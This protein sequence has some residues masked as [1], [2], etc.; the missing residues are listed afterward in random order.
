M[1][2][3]G[4]SRFCAL[5]RFYDAAVRCGRPHQ[6]TASLLTLGNLTR[7]WTTFELADGDGAGARQ[8]KTQRGVASLVAPCPRGHEEGCIF[9]CA[10]SSRSRCNNPL[11][12]R[13]VLAVTMQPSLVA[14]CPRGPIVTGRG[15]KPSHTEATLKRGCNPYLV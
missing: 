4:R 10:L 6:V 9:G 15:G 1:S 14:P 11:W 13:L 5:E 7:V 2:S 12:L 8:A 3:F